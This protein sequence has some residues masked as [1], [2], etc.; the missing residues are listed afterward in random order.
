MTN[1]IYNAMLRD[2]AMLREI[3]NEDDFFYVVDPNI[4][5]LAEKFAARDAIV[6]RLDELMLEGLSSIKC[7]ESL[8]QQYPD[9]SNLIYSII[10]EKFSLEDVVR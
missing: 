8:I 2:A 1:K 6:E 9:E 10:S 3:N 5:P 4:N 7:Y